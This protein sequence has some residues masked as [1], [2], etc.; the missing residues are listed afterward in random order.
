M[1]SSRRHTPGLNSITPAAAFLSKGFTLVEVM[2]ALAVIAI[3]L[4]ALL[5][6]VMQ[7]LDGTAY[8]RDKNIAQWV[9]LNKMTELRLTNRQTGKIPKGKLTGKEEMAGR[10]WHW[11]VRSKRFPQKEFSDLYGIEI[12]IREKDDAKKPAVATLIGILQAFDP[13]P[14]NRTNSPPSTPRAP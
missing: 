8:I 4:P 10:D 14:I 9:A 7:Q 12:I 13:A 11:S 5:F 6:S 1:N 2:V 3:A